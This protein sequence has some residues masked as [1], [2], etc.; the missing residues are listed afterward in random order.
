M[1]NACACGCGR[2]AALPYARPYCI[3]WIRDECIDR[4]V[5]E[6]A[7]LGDVARAVLADN[8]AMC[9]AGLRERLPFEVERDGR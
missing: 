3:G 6:L 5:C 2:P 7:Q 4:L 8:G 1:L 9:C